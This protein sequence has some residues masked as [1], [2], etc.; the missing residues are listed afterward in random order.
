MMTLENRTCPPGLEERE[1]GSFCF[2]GADSLLWLGKIQ[3]AV[4][5]PPRWKPLSNVCDTQPLGLI[6]GYPIN[7]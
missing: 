7:T 1:V 5:K 3:D 2:H 6:W 4:A